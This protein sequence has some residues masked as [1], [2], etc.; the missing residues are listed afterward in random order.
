MGV[1]VGVGFKDSV[2]VQNGQY[3]PSGA[4]GPHG[5]PGGTFGNQLLV[6]GHL[7]GGRGGGGVVG[8]LG[9]AEPPLLPSRSISG[10]S[11]LSWAPEGVPGRV[12]GGGGFIP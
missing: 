10:W 12:G 4:F 11:A 2:G 6:R 7:A 1:G 3:F 8:V 9:P 5:A